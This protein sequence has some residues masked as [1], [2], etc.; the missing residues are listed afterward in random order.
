MPLRFG[1]KKSFLAYQFLN[2]T[3]PKLITMRWS[4]KSGYKNKS[5]LYSNESSIHQPEESNYF[6]KS[7]YIVNTTIT[8]NE[9]PTQYW[10]EE[11]I[12]SSH[13]FQ[14]H[15]YEYAGK[16]F[17]EN[18]Y[19]S[20]LD[21]GAGPGT[22][23]PHF[24]NLPS[25]DLSLI[26]QPGMENI[27]SKFCPESQF[28]GKNLENGA[29]DLGKKFDFIICADVIEHLSNPSSLLKIIKTHL[30]DTGLVI[31]STPDR[32]MRRGKNNIQSPNK[33]HVREWNREE[34]RRLMEAHEF[35]IEEHINLPLKKLNFLMLKISQKIF[36]EIIN[37]ANWFANQTLVLSHKHL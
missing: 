19:K 27:V 4:K 32:D 8:F 3:Y 6:I 2:V 17:K 28:Y 34:L 11:R 16:L 26:D 9:S 21:I 13:Y 31:L 35:K 5:N 24:F 22:K 1:M 18:N 23:I 29:L 7:N 14:Y 20:L 30:K 10:T 37:K 36:Y 33:A 25:L 15:V 12:K